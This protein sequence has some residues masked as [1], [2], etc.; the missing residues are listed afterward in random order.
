MMTGNLVQAFLENTS[1]NLPTS[2]DTGRIASINR[3]KATMDAV[4]AYILDHQLKPGDPL[5]TEVQL[6][7]DLGVS[8]S[9]VREAIRKL[10]AL[11]IVRVQQGRGSFV[12]EMSL[13][14][15]VETLI[16]RYALDHFEGSESL[17]HVVAIRR[18]IDLGM[19]NSLAREMKGTSNPEL[20]KL[21]ATMIE[22]A[23]AGQTYLEEDIA[24]HNGLASYLDNSLLNQLVAAM[25]MVHQSFIPDMEETIKRDLVCTAKAHA[26]MLET[27]QAGDA[28]AY[29]DAV[30]AHYEPLA[31]I[32]DLS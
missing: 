6:C 22:K 26:L 25:W 12:G 8:R 19:S 30:Y 2:L 18:Y 3:S 7:E 15:M 23:E 14:P 28:D 32:L 20:E 9:S 29:R 31:N 27:A 1:K 10:E 4:K 17:R 21:V 11:D 16:L 24:F 5:P 13:Q